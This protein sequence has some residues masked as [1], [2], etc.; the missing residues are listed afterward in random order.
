MYKIPCQ[1]VRVLGTDKNQ[2]STWMQIKTLSYKSV[3]LQHRLADILVLAY[4]PGQIMRYHM[5]QHL[6][7]GIPRC[8]GLKAGVHVTAFS[9][10]A[11]TAKPGQGLLRRLVMLWETCPRRL[12]LPDSLQ[13]DMAK[14]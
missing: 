14:R 10:G 3:A 7:G 1:S 11:A 5:A 9:G 2:E 4:I 8:P 6:A 12:W 13:Y